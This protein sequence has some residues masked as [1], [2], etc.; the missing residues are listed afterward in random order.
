M[1]P[2][3]AHVQAIMG[4]IP[5]NVLLI[6]IARQAFLI[7]SAKMGVSSSNATQAVNG[8][9]FSPVL[10][11]LSAISTQR[12]AIAQRFSLAQ[13]MTLSHLQWI[14][15]FPGNFSF[16]RASLMA[17]AITGLMSSRLPTTILLG[18][19]TQRCAYARD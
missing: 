7:A 2:G 12:A 3:M 11:L 17:I 15:D 5:Q 16:K 13:P 8:R 10:G 9:R 4:I 6:M 19:N 14:N 18:M 1:P